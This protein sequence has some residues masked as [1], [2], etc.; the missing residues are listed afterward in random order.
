MI[1]AGCGSE[2][3]SDGG[4]KL[5]S[6]YHTHDWSDWDNHTDPTCVDN[7]AK[8][9]YCKDGNCAQEEK[10]VV[11]AV[12]H[13]DTCGHEYCGVCI[14]FDCGIDHK[15]LEHTHD[16]SGEW[17]Q[18]KDPTCTT[19]G[20]KSTVCVTDGCDAVEHQP[21]AAH[22]HT[23]GEWEQLLAPT[24]STEGMRRRV[25]D[26]DSTH[27]EPVAADRIPATGIHG[28]AGCTHVKCDEHNVWY[29]NGG[30]CSEKH[31]KEPCS[32]FMGNQYSCFNHLE[33][34]INTAGSL[35]SGTCIE[36]RCN[37]YNEDVWI[38][39]NHKVV[40][41]YYKALW[42]AWTARGD[43]PHDAPRPAQVLNN[44]LYDHLFNKNG[45][46]YYDFVRPNEWPCFIPSDYEAAW[47]AAE[48]ENAKVH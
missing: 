47:A 17:H 34:G 42:D 31:P 22:G 38:E 25:C 37:F 28:G 6:D 15:S 13:T 20:S 23:W 14:D 40:Y 2:P 46:N 44:P 24:C 43:K 26:H 3:A 7:G 12:G 33:T 11:A 4:G 41:A 27:K 19:T 48:A 32:S 5:G 21:V 8:S 35:A 9:R 10:R 39:H 18:Y 29:V 1:A 36:K 30:N 45:N 16:F